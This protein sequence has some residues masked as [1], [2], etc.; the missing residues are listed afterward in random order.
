MSES[1]KDFLGM[2]SQS[3]TEYLAN[4]SKFDK[5]AGYPRLPYD[6]TKPA[7]RNEFGGKI[8]VIK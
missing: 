3:M 1:G 6:I 4:P 7:S 8:R 2:G 5:V